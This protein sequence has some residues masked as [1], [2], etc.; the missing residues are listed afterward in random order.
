MLAKKTLIIAAGIIL[1]AN[2]VALGLY[3]SG[4][5]GSWTRP[6]EAT[7][8]D[9]SGPQ[10]KIVAPETL[11]DFGE[12]AA[13]VEQ[14]HSF[15]IRNEGDAPLQIREVSISCQC[16]KGTAEKTLLAP[17]ESG[18]ID[19]SWQPTKKDP[20]F[21]QTI[22]LVT[23]DPRYPDLHE[24]KL[25]IKGKVEAMVTVEPE[26]EWKVGAIAEDQ[27]TVVHGIIHSM[28]LDSIKILDIKT[29]HPLL[30]AVATPLDKD[31]L[32]RLHAKS[33]YD[34]KVTLEPGI[35]VGTFREKVVVKTDIAGGSD[36]PW[37]LSGERYGP[38]RIVPKPGADWSHKH[39]TLN[40]GRFP[41]EKGNKAEV[42]MMVSGL[43]QSD[44]MSFVDIKS[45]V[46]YLTLKLTP[47]E[48]NATAKEKKYILR[49][50]VP[51][52]SPQEARTGAARAKI[53]VK[54]NHPKAEQL[55]FRVDF[56]TL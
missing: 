55:E 56:V 8:I 30:K 13:G 23:N 14:K 45:D 20:G 21:Q 35:Q 36:V 27:P 42:M 34:I 28:A 46:P 10:P 3:W 38:F 33:G 54:T 18:M 16:T 25:N 22:K 26:T 12:M 48:A 51:P 1:L 17:G 2:A 44:E 49:F 43:E 41:A 29:E 19:I 6:A 15:L 24:F 11:H 53:K 32:L 39:M 37:F 31:E 5:V 47:H 40:L 4:V 9:L 7:A 52:G 50:E